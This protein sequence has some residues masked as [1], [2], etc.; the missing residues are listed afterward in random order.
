MNAPVIEWTDERVQTLKAMWKAEATV[1]E[2]S[3]ALIGSRK[4]RNSVI[5][6]AH[7][8]KL[9]PHANVQKPISP[10]VRAIR[11]AEQLTKLAKR[12]ERG[13]MEVKKP[14]E[15]KADG[16]WLRSDVWK[17]LP[18]N[19]PIHLLDLTQHTCRWPVGD[20]FCG[21]HTLEGKVYCDFHYTRSVQKNTGEMTK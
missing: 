2:I 19:L 16:K 21:H 8:L 18:G 17:P 13:R 9:S 15:P 10:E 20:L 4:G 1:G 12:K 7:R 3:V 11:A 14:P 5:S 6:K